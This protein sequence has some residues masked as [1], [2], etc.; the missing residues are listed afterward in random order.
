MRS[1][2]TIIYFINRWINTYSLLVTLL[3][4]III[5]I[6]ILC[7]SLHRY[8]PLFYEA[9]DVLVFYFLIKKSFFRL[10]LSKFLH[11]LK[12][13]AWF[14]IFLSWHACYKHFLFF[15][16]CFFLDIFCYWLLLISLCLFC[17]LALSC[18]R[19]IKISEEMI[20]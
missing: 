13:L 15:I 1:L 10:F 4:I 18:R 6:P 19:K 16:Y 20:W 17:L 14:S 8:L 12:I 3:K 2:R 7:L 9:N 5:L 11:F